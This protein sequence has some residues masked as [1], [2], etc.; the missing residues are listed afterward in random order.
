MIWERICADLRSARDVDYL[1][2]TVTHYAARY[3]FEYC[4]YSV[5]IPAINTKSRF[6][7]FN[8]CPDGWAENYQAELYHEKDPLILKVKQSVNPVIWCEKA[9]SENIKIW[10]L[11]KQYNLNTGIS[12]PSWAANDVF[13]NL[14]FLRSENPVTDQEVQELRSALTVIGNFLHHTMYQFLDLE[15]ELRI[16]VVTLTGREREILRWTSE[17]KTAEVVGTI[18]SISTRTVNFHISN[19]LT[20]LT[21]VNKVQAVVKAQSLGLI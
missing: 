14:T 4:I 3:G 11:A 2:D 12:V 5:N 9:F 17:G 10:Q 13:G 8:N 15:N 6:Y 16:P 18:L 7:L 19:I 1:F 20:K 21:A